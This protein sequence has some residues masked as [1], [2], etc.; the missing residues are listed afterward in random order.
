VISEVLHL[1]YDI[2][3]NL[4]YIDPFIFFLYIFFR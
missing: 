3:I 2:I 4:H 1:L